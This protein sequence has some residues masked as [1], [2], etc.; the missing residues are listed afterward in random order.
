MVAT[1]SVSPSSSSFPVSL[2]F[3]LLLSSQA[4]FTFAHA[5]T[6]VKFLPGFQ[7]P[8][9]FHL[10]TGYV[11][12]GESEDVQLFY[13]FVESERSP[14]QDPLVLWL[15]GGP[16]CSALSSLL[17]EIGPIHFRIEEYNGTLPTLDLNPDSW[18]KVSSIIFIDLPAHTG[19]SYTTL[20]IAPQR[21]DSKQIQHA[22]QFFWKWLTIHSEFR[23]NPIYVGGDSYS[24][25]I[26]PAVAL[27]ISKGYE[28]SIDTAINFQETP[29]QTVL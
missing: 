10:E 1:S 25:L 29:E 18:T 23:S 17:F 15:T 9:P 19:F 21:S 2:L 28:N 20:P 11:G 16:G 5:R 27:E 26:V 7:G 22:V 3:L 24:G 12:V 4:C 6:T 8:L 14:K 13:Y